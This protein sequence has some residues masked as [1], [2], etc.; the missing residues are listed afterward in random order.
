MPYLCTEL[1]FFPDE[2]NKSINN[3]KAYNKRAAE[4]SLLDYHDIVKSQCIG[5]RK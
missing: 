2:Q 1:L 3:E 5:K 4:R